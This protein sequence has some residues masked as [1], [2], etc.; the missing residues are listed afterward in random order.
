MIGIL[1]ARDIVE[2][3]LETPFGGGRHKKRLDKIAELE[4]KNY[5]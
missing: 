1:P 2:K 4:K 3:W 5:R